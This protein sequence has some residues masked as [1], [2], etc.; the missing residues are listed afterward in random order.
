MTVDETSQSIAY[1]STGNATEDLIVTNYMTGTVVFNQNVVASE[2]TNGPSPWI[3]AEWSR[4][5][6]LPLFSPGLYIVHVDPAAVTPSVVERKQNTYE[7]PLFVVPTTPTA[8]MVFIFPSL[9]NTCYNQWGGASC[10]SKPHQPDVGFKRPGV[11][12]AY[13]AA[14]KRVILRADA[15]GITWDAID[16]QY[17]EDNPAFLQNYR[18]AVAVFQPEYV[19]LAMRDAYEDYMNSG[20]RLA[21]LGNEAWIYQVRRAGDT[22]SVYKTPERLIDPF[23]SDGDPSN[24]HL[25]AY[26]W[27]RGTP[28]SN[29]TGPNRPETRVLGQSTW[30]GYDA[31]YPYWT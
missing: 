13:I 30:L 21:I 22:Y 14:L 8:D 9:T 10:Y 2:Q 6:T 1:I 31:A 12:K 29:T 11:Y 15:L 18:A 26:E 7:M 5:E 3:N 24:D 23:D 19:T 28:V 16:E 25:I 20:G 4:S 27:V 17:I